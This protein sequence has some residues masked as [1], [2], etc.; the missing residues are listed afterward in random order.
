[1]APRSDCDP[2]ET[3]RPFVQTSHRPSAN[4]QSR[5][6][7]VTWNFTT[8]TNIVA[9]ATAAA[10]AVA[11]GVIAA[12]T[13]SAVEA[14]ANRLQA[15]SHTLLRTTERVTGKN[16]GVG[17]SEGLTSA[18][19]G[20]KGWVVGFFFFKPSPHRSLAT[21]SCCTVLSTASEGGG[22][23]MGGWVE[24]RG[25]RGLTP[26]PPALSPPPSTQRHSSCR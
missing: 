12:A 4:L 6:P 9:A 16:R 8:A 19:E 3:R 24:V 14:A 20:G 25:V 13:A 15:T 11:G 2:H 21:P 10:V 1:M 5:W 7:A 22:G 17:I 23:W 26:L 18:V